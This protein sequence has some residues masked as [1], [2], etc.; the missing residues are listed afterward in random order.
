MRTESA[1]AIALVALI[2]AAPGARA[3][4]PSGPQDIGPLEKAAKP[5]TPENPIPR[6]VAAFAAPYPAEAAAVEARATVTLR[7]TL[8]TGGRVGEVRLV[9]ISARGQTPAFSVN[10]TSA[11]VKDRDSLL[12]LQLSQADART[13]GAAIDAL[14]RAAIETAKM[15]SYDPPA[16]API[17]F[18]VAFGF[19]PDT[20]PAET[21]GDPAPGVLRRETPDDLVRVGDNVQPPGKIHNVTPVYPKLALSARIQGTVVI[22]ARIERD[23]TVSHAQVMQSIALLDEPALDAVLQWRF[24]PTLVDGKPVPVLMT[25]RVGF[26]L[27]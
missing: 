16:D 4:A 24:T 9:A 15:W 27:R 17:A 22:E 14:A 18:T 12:A 26:T 19:T 8:D 25:V 6:R 11:G 5:I 2:A 23:G 20:T 13:V 7:V 1:L 10:F 3:Q 21:H